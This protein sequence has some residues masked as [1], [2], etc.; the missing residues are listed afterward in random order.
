MEKL[1]HRTALSPGTD[2]AELRDMFLLGFLTVTSASLAV[3]LH[4]LRKAPEG[5]EDETGF[6]IIHGRARYSGASI[7]PRRSR[8][9]EVVGGRLHLPLAASAAGPVKA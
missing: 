3:I 8:D 4:A 7:L 9:R 5:F 2:P 1:H 6:H